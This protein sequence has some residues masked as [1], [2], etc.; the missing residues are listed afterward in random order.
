[1]KIN[2]LKYLLV[3][4]F[5]NQILITS[6]KYKLNETGDSGHPY[7]TPWVIA[8]ESSD[9]PLPALTLIKFSINIFWII[10]IRWVGIALLNIIVHNLC[11]STDKHFFKINERNICGDVKLS[12]FFNNLWSWEYAVHAGSAFPKIRSALLIVGPLQ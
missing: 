10:V 1:M 11:L 3:F 6:S 12:K 8:L 2:S 5:C 4:S 9:I 7:L